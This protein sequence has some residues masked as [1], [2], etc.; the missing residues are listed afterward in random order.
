M[1]A[2]QAFTPSP[3]LFFVIAVV[4]VTIVFIFS[5]VKQVPQAY[6]FTLERF[7]R[8]TRTL[9]PGLHL[10]VPFIDRIGHKLS[11]QESV[12]DIP[13]QDVIT[14]DNA[15]VTCDAVCFFQIVDADRAAY[16]VRDLPRAMT[17]ITMTNIR[18]VIGSMPLD[19]VLSKRDDINE[20]LLRVIDAA[21]NPWGVKVT[22]VEIKDLS[23]PRDLV[24]AMAM[25]MKAERV[26]RAEI[27]KAEGDKQSAV[28]RAEGQKQAA[29]LEAE[30]RRE[31][32]FRDAEAREREGEAEGKAT[33][34]LSEA[35]AAGNVNAVNYFVAQRYVSALEKMGS[36]PNQKII[37]IP[38]E[39]TGVI[40][41][42]AG[43]AEIAKAALKETRD[44]PSGAGPWGDRADG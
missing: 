6:E 8:Y 14:M 20:R 9:S 32:A 28:L 42:L 17:N 43:I 39:A 25:Q 27:L 12:L 13:A 18:S 2:V 5:G 31:A 3:F 21:T 16:E 4:F 34:S 44:G 30:G 26:K 37:M 23:P 40:G 35:I 38:F 41:S 22:R 11:M 29:I 1:D 7:G 19:D 24:D 15:S 36:A 33:T 10:I